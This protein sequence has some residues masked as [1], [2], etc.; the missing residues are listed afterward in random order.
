MKLRPQ[1][2]L[3]VPIAKRQKH[4]GLEVRVSCCRQKGCFPVARYGAGVWVYELTGNYVRRSGRLSRLR[5]P[6]RAAVEPRSKSKREEAG[7]SGLLAHLLQR[8]LDQALIERDI[9]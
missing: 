4:P 1:E 6:D 8:F 3:G 5:E 9:L 7:E 2:R